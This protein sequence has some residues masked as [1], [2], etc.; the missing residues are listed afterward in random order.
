MNDMEK[1]CKQHGHN[2]IISTFIK[3][4][5]WYNIFKLWY[6]NYHYIAII[7]ITITLQLFLSLLLQLVLSLLLLQLLSSLLS[8]N[9]GCTI[10]K[11]IN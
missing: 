6:H 9:L 7:I 3:V 1:P 5:M 2:F 4:V 11:C 8:T 10:Y